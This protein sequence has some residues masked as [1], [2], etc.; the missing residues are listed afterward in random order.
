M[1]QFL[2]RHFGT[3]QKPPTKPTYSWSRE[4]TLCIYTNFD[5]H[6]KGSKVERVFLLELAMAFVYANF[7]AFF[8]DGRPKRETEKFR[9]SRRIFS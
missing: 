6:N 5:P 3:T 4:P 7:A 9:G 2:G 8:A 1:G